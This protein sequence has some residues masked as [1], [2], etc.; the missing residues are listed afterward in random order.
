MMEN[1]LSDLMGFR[2]EEVV[3]EKPQPSRRERRAAA[4]HQATRARKATKRWAVAGENE[5]AARARLD[6]MVERMTPQDRA[7]FE[8]RAAELQAEQKE[9]GR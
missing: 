8:K 3:D 4:R 2:A 7:D 9:A 5:E 1:M 6:R